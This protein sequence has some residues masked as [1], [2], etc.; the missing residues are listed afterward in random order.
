MPLC[1]MLHPPF[2][3]AHEY[4]TAATGT[5]LC[6]PAALLSSPL[7]RAPSYAAATQA[8]RY[9]LGVCPNFA[10]KVRLKCE[11]CS[12]PHSNRISVTLMLVDVS[13]CAAHSRRRSSSQRP[14]AT[15]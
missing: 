15:P 5:C 12:K 1:L 6:G 2:H 10:L 4:R 8:S 3:G 7:L 14:G 9:S 13:R 11:A